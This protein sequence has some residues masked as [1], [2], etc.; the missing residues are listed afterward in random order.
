MLKSD[1][2][3]ESGNRILNLVIIKNLAYCKQYKDDN[4]Q[5]QPNEANNV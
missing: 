1:F 4:K 5:I 3:F 2:D